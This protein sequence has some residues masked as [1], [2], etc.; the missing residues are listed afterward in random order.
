MGNAQEL[1]CPVHNNAPFSG[2]IQYTVT[3]ISPREPLVVATQPELSNEPTHSLKSMRRSRTIFPL[4]GSS[5]CYII[6]GFG[7]TVRRRS[8]HCPGSAVQYG[9]KFSMSMATE[10][11]GHTGRRGDFLVLHSV[12]R[13]R[14]TPLEQGIGIP[15]IMAT[16]RRLNNGRDIRYPR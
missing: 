13:L 15:G 11:S 1:L 14:P 10:D 16:E 9:A 4:L 5:F 6:G 2:N 3:R 7:K 8:G 12:S